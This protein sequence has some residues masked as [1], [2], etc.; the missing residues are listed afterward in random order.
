M[1]TKTQPQMHKEP[2]NAEQRYETTDSDR[3]R[4]TCPETSLTP[5]QVHSQNERSIRSERRLTTPRERWFHFSSLF[6]RRS[7]DVNTITTT[8]FATS[9]ADVG[10]TATLARP[11]P[12]TI[13]NSTTTI[14]TLSPQNNDPENLP[15]VAAVLPRKNSKRRSRNRSQSG[16]LY[17]LATLA[18]T[19]EIQLH[20]RNEKDPD[21]E[22]LGSS[23]LKRNIDSKDKILLTSMAADETAQTQI[24]LE[25]IT[26][27]GLNNSSKSGLRASLMSYLSKF[28]IWKNSNCR[29]QSKRSSRSKQL[30][31]PSGVVYNT[32]PSSS[33]GPRK[34]VN[35]STDF[36]QFPAADNTD[37]KVSDR[38]V[39]A[40]E[41]GI[42]RLSQIRRRRSSYYFS[43][44]ERR[45]RANDREFNAQFKYADNYI[46]TSKYSL[47]TFLPFNLLEQFQRL[48]NFY[49]LCL[50][51]LQLIPAIS[52]L[53][54][55]TTAIP[56]IGVL[57][58]T[59]VKDAYDDIQRHLSDSQVNNRKSKT[60]RNGKLVDERWSGVQVGDVIRMENNQFVAA[61]ILL[62]STSEPNGLCFIE[63]AELDGE[64]NLK[65][66]Q[67]L[68]ETIELGQQDDLLW[69]FNG[70][71]I[72]EKPNNLL[73]KFEGTL[74]W[75]NQRFALDN[76]KILLRGCVLRNTQWCYGVVIFAGKDTKLMQNSGKTQFKS[77][78]VDRLLNFIIIG[79]VLFLLSIC[80]FFTV[81]CALWEGFI[82]QHFQ[83]YL[84]WENIIPKN[85][86]QG[87]T[88]IGLLVFFSYAIVLNTVVPISLYVSVEVIRFVQ[89]FLINWDEEMYYEPTKTHAKART[90]TLNEELG[91]IQYIFSDKTGTLTQNIMTFNKCSINGRT[92]GDVFDLRTGEVVE[93]TDNEFQTQN[94]NSTIMK[95][96]LDIGTT[97]TLRLH[98]VDVHRSGGKTPTTPTNN[99]SSKIKQL[100]QLQEQP[101]TT[102][103][104]TTTT[105]SK[106]LNSGS[107]TTTP[108]NSPSSWDNFYLKPPDTVAGVAG[109]GGVTNTPH[110]LITTA[111]V[112][113]ENPIFH[114]NDDANVNSPPS[115]PCS[116]PSPQGKRVKY[117]KEPKTHRRAAKLEP[118]SEKARVRRQAS[119][120]ST[121]SDKVIILGDVAI[122]EPKIIATTTNN[123]TNNTT[124]YH[125]NNNKPPHSNNY[126]IQNLNQNKSDFAS[127][128]LKRKLNG[129]TPN[130]AIAITTLSPT[131]SSTV[132]THL[133]N[134]NPN[135]KNQNK[136]FRFSPFSKK[137]HTPPLIETVTMTTMSSPSSSAQPPTHRCRPQFC[138]SF[139]S[140]SSSSLRNED[141][142][143]RQDFVTMYDDCTESSAHYLYK[144]STYTT[145]TITT[146]STNTK[147]TNNIKHNNTCDNNFLK[148]PP[149]SDLHFLNHDHVNFKTA[150]ARN[151]T[152]D[153]I[154]NNVHHKQ[155]VHTVE[156][157]DFSANPE[158]EPEFRWY[159]RTL[160]D[161]VRSDE[162]HAHNFFRLLALCHTVMP[163]YVEDRL[164]YQ[165]QSPDESALV[166]AARNF[167]FVFRSRTPNSITIEVMGR[168]EEYELLHIL[169]FNNVRKRMSVI[170]R[171]G[172]KIFLY[173]KGADSV[174]YDRLSS[175]QHDIKA[176]TQDH[177]NKFA[178]EG[179]RTLVLAERHLSPE[180]YEDWSKRHWEA[181]VSLDHREEKLNAI[182]EEIESELVL[183]GVTAIEDKLQDGVPQTIA[184]L[185]MAGIKVWVL[186]GDKQ[187]T[188]INIGYSCQLLT[189]DLADVFIVD[190]S[191]IE[192]VDKQLRQFK[193]S[194]R[195]VNR[196]RPTPLE[197]AVNLNGSHLNDRS[198]SSLKITQ[199]SPPPPP[200]ISVVTFSAE[201]NELYDSLEKG[202]SAARNV[203]RDDEIVEENT[204]FAIVIN[205][206]SLVHCLSPELETK[207]LDIASQCKA[208]ICCRVTPLQKA[209]VVELIKRAKNAVTLAI[210]DGANDVSMIKAAHIGVGIS[211]QEGLQAVLASDYS[212]AQFRYLERLLLVHGRWS[213]YRMCKFL[214]YFF[215]KN[216]A[217]TLCHCWYSFFCGFSAQTVFD[218][219]FISVYNLFYTSLPVL[220]LGVFEQDVSDRHSVDFPKLYTPGLK[221]QLFNTKE[222]V[223]SVLHGAFSSLILFLIPYGT[224]HKGVSPNG[225]ILSDHMT[226]GAVVATILIIDNTA[227][228]ALYTSYWTIFN[229]I[230]IW[231]SL[232]W[233][234]VLDYFYNYVVGGPYVGSLTMAMKDLTFWTTMFITVVLIMIPVLAYKFYL[235]DC[236]PSLAD[237]I[238]MKRRQASLKLR[239]TSSVMRAPSSRRS[240][241][242]LRSGYAFAHQEGF[243][244]LITSGKIMRKLPQEFA[245]PLGLGSKKV[246]S[247][248]AT[249]DAKTN[250]NNSTRDNNKNSSMDDNSLNNDALTN[251]TETNI[252][253]L[254]PRA[255]CQDLDTINL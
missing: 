123:T 252:E 192:E 3:L 193:E 140:C 21:A 41:M 13:D 222:F 188:A 76:E 107:T 209:L 45:I 204:G 190:G 131:N 146:P 148:P 90:T 47:M 61:D 169:D 94:S 245:F 49:F 98:K 208:V 128:S 20:S 30:T 73:N 181:S 92:Y 232:I 165:A 175:S 225:L 233:Y 89:S 163:E 176:R 145:T 9:T 24:E 219:M 214:R 237:K 141:Q 75:R 37:D 18:Q 87:S 78:G 111:K 171:R 7:R 100:H 147:C 183:V 48:A 133:Q 36:E 154:W 88:V 5:L 215:Y 118:S 33:L 130:T 50:L 255:P 238:R 114:N 150:T 84:P 202:G 226:L 66:K 162:E 103:N 173:C 104:N 132:V 224:Y 151:S 177:L 64:T 160:L 210:G 91:Q 206:H 218:P 199:V 119:T 16:S 158:Y 96:K 108:I 152:T 136:K 67:C 106:Q 121:C 99:V 105:T 17:S 1:G 28:N 27:D 200:A 101:T 125:S 63:T 95:N 10:T 161:A 239:Q 38:F 203:L 60:L 12:S 72:C 43:E 240:R 253:G 205:G 157:V 112:E 71:I 197:P 57:T 6:A 179:L 170:L 231:G 52:S 242:S 235:I 254:S 14:L 212:I 142:L 164:E 172:D 8:T 223:Y 85:V 34:S 228:I 40:K 220:A 46:K 138:T 144:K 211:G 81:A 187:E 32:G 120:L 70:E 11:E 241:R 44:N 174:I 244:R 74:I 246:Q 236:Q 23:L 82:G 31:T 195:I 189:D 217:F 134:P 221:S 213:Y 243:G 153:H 4:N 248:G 251:N 59:A 250:N 194:I 135:K 83:S 115:S 126:K 149:P 2:A 247:S 155:Q 51:V 79:I 166:S 186:T 167:G 56:L 62:L 35:I 55:V 54:P 110:T 80:A 230:T 196:F 86:L 180:F 168:K 26:A 178:G 216:F 68:T 69:N 137:T 39:N 42:R 109:G 122:K 139:C 97:A 19:G 116:T 124:T 53:T 65:C 191:T 234:F 25:E 249:Q 15:D 127:V 185:Q 143:N 159:D 229:H 184:N 182:M 58:L 227:Q 156:P 102:T 198:P 117:A 77:T 129:S 93:I 22:A 113:I 207:F 201:T 29:D